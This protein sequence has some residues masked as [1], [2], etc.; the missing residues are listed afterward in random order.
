MAFVADR[1]FSILPL[2]KAR[3]ILRAFGI[4]WRGHAKT[5]FN[6]VVFR[7]EC[8]DEIFQSNADI[9]TARATNAGRGNH[10][11]MWFFDPFPVA[12]NF[13]FD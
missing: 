8:V 11:N 10:G 12:A 4:E 9:K 1:V 2:P 3:F 6:L 7:F 5:S 13:E